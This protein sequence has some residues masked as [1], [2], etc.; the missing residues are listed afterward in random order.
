MEISEYQDRIDEVPVEA[1]LLSK[2]K[3]DMLAREVE[4]PERD[5]RHAY[6]DL[7]FRLRRE[8]EWESDIRQ[9]METVEPAVVMT[10]TYLI[11]HGDIQVREALVEKGYDVVQD[12]LAKVEEAV[13]A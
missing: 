8:D 5:F 9:W 3:I 1:L 2:V 6:A 4:I 11:R 13:E 12:L 10:L 7:L